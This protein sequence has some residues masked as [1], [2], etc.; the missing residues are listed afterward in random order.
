ML[1]GRTTTI[2]SISEGNTADVTIA[3]LPDIV[4][5]DSDDWLILPKFNKSHTTP[6]G[7]RRTGDDGGG[8]GC[9][10]GG[11]GGGGK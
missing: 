8:G 1:F 2:S 3:I 10:S 9:P 5:A 11:G 4:A 6:A 7:W